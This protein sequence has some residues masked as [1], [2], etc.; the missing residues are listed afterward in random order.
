M[1]FSPKNPDTFSVFRFSLIFSQCSLLGFLLFAVANDN[2][3]S[4]L[5]VALCTTNFFSLAELLDS[6]Q[7]KRVVSQDALEIYEEEQSISS[8]FLAPKGGLPIKRLSIITEST[9]ISENS[10]ESD[11]EKDELTV[12]SSFLFCASR[13]ESVTNEKEEGENNCERKLISSP[14]M[15]F[16]SCEDVRSSIVTSD[17]SL[18][19][20]SNNQEI[21]LDQSLR[22]TRQN[23]NLS[24]GTSK[25][26]IDAYS[27]K[28]DPQL[29]MMGSLNSLGETSET[30]LSS[31]MRRFSE[32]ANNNG[33]YDDLPTLN[34][35]CRDAPQRRPLNP[36]KSHENIGPK[37][38]LDGVRRIKSPIGKQLSARSLSERSLKASNFSRKGDSIENRHHCVGNTNSLDDYNDS[39]DEIRRSDASRSS[40]TTSFSTIG[41][42]YTRTYKK[43]KAST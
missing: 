28:S 35:D 5:N 41:S 26:L 16:V 2:V 6:F 19:N 33:S 25:S 24:N 7:E 8:K 17:S 40:S 42:G 13:D 36:S 31:D 27:H 29:N 39:D 11:V 30:L 21:F 4:L 3:I 14:E 20:E 12:K 38:M 1:I 18:D 34:S 15:K 23:N 10:I 37:K 43:V 32:R 9:I 22:F